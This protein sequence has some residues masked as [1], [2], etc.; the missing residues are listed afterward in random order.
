MFIN[1]MFDVLY[2][3]YVKIRDFFWLLYIELF[4]RY[5][6]VLRYLEDLF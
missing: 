5:G 6:I 2:D 1:R 4:L 3:L